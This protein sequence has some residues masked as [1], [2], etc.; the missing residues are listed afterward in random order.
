MLPYRMFQKENN[1]KNNN[2]INRIYYN[3]IYNH[4]CLG[5]NGEIISGKRLKRNLYSWNIWLPI[6]FLSLG[7]ERKLPEYGREWRKKGC[8]GVK[9]IFM[10]KEGNISSPNLTDH[11]SASSSGQRHSCVEAELGTWDW[12]SSPGLYSCCCFMVSPGFQAYCVASSQ[13][14]K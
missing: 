1:N 9:A 11:H 14:W 2:N 8:R 6:V 3:M 10:A 4:N 5:Q 12:H 7:K 13:Q